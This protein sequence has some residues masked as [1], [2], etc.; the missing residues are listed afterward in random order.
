[1]GLR[2]GK[3][4]ANKTQDAPRWTKDGRFFLRDRES[5]ARHSRLLLLRAGDMEENPGPNHCGWCKD[6]VKEANYLSCKN[7]ETKF[8]MKRFCS[9]LSRNDARTTGR[10]NTLLCF[11]CA[12]REWLECALCSSKFHSSQKGNKC[13]D[14]GNSYHYKCA[15]VLRSQKGSKDWKCPP[16]K[17]EH[18]SQPQQ[19][20]NLE[21]A[22][23]A[24]CAGLIKR[25]HNRNK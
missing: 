25:G 22:T 13:C 15:K 18:L 5:E 9:G 10:D 8:H 16:C 1:M 19:P 24:T 11:M 2:K 17:G 3:Y 7:C 14:C 12:R 23:C 21:Q 4:V 6:L 20:S